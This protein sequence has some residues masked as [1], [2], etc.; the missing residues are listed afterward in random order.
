M[1]V[2][3]LADVDFQAVASDSSLF[4]VPFLAGATAFERGDREQALSMFELA[5]SGSLK[6]KSVPRLY[7]ATYLGALRLSMGR[8][9]EAADGLATTKADDFANAPASLVWQNRFLFALAHE[10][11]GKL[12]AALEGYSYAQTLE[13]KVVAE[14]SALVTLAKAWLLIRR[15]DAREA[16][17]SLQQMQKTLARCKPL[18]EERC[19]T[20]LFTHARLVTLKSL[21]AGMLGR[22][23]DARACAQQVE[24]VTSEVRELVAG[25]GALTDDALKKTLVEPLSPDLP[26]TL[27]RVVASQPGGCAMVHFPDALNAIMHLDQNDSLSGDAFLQFYDNFKQLKGSLG[28]MLRSL[29]ATFAKT[30]EMNMGCTFSLAALS[31]R[32]LDAAATVAAE[33]SSELD[34]YSTPLTH[35]ELALLRALPALHLPAAAPDRHRRVLQS[36]AAIRENLPVLRTAMGPDAPTVRMWE[37]AIEL[38]ALPKSTPD[39]TSTGTC[40]AN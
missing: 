6:A 30:Y 11:Q 31:A 33:A 36:V 1:D 18:T 16:L 39:L 12:V 14:S 21:A 29:P 2:V 40:A 17:D 34:K 10:E 35:T 24:D 22:T 3:S 38:H 5:A 4:F 26:P 7:A 8:T 32:Q 13:G 28:A 15:G 19:L 27:L 37:R 20:A 23:S 9:A 25:P